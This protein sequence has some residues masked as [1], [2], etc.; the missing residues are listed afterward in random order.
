M[1]KLEDLRAELATVVNKGWQEDITFPFYIYIHTAKQYFN[2][3][4]L[5]K[6]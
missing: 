2:I 4:W 3:V 1:L 6:R 5:T